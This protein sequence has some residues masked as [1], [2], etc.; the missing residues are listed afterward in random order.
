MAGIS[1]CELKDVYT[2]GVDTSHPDNQ[3][4]EGV[5]HFLAV[6]TI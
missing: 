1:T 4:N 5:K 3:V 6:L 2:R